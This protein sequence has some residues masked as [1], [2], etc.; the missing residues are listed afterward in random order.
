[1]RRR[2]LAPSIQVL[3]AA[4]I[5]I[6]LLRMAQDWSVAAAPAFAVAA[7]ALWLAQRLRRFVRELAV[8]A[9]VCG[10]LAASQS[11]PDAVTAAAAGAFL[12]AGLGL[13][14]VGRRLAR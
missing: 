3:A 14:L 13:V 7:A 11:G 1:V 2:F 8:A 6:S 12:A 9:A 4:V 10:Y 5:T